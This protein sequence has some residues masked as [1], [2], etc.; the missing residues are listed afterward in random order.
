[1]SWGDGH[2]EGSAHAVLGDFVYL[3]GKKAV[4][5]APVLRQV[6]CQ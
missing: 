1:V 5:H 4:F 3:T 6:Q 2:L